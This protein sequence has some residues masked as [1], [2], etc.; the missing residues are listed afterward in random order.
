MP[1]MLRT[2]AYDTI[3]HEHL[4]FYSFKII[5]EILDKCN[6]KVIDV[7]TN[8]INGGS[9]AVTACKKN[10][11]YK[12]NTPIIQWMLSQEREMNLQTLKP[13]KEFED[14]I[15]QHKKNLR[16]L[17]ESLTSS[18]KIVAGYGASTK[19][20]VLFQF[21]ELTTKHIPYI[22]EIN[23]EKFG[24][25]TPGTNIPIISE[26]EAKFRKPDYFLVLPWHFKSSILE[27]E[28]DF[29]SAGGKLIF[30]LPEIEII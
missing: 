12:A 10:A 20:N 13:Y 11:H 5:C 18:G 23:E 29:L 7:Q 16:S 26:D 22:A 2:N 21:C 8:S 30:P 15:Y 6:M 4:E 14:R 17:V 1:S 28:R 3:C 27:R 9:F 25:F 19:G 24:A